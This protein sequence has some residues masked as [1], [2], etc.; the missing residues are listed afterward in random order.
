MLQHF[1]VE[2]ISTMFPKKVRTLTKDETMNKIKPFAAF[3]LA[4]FFILIMLDSSSAG[5]IRHRHHSR[6]QSCL[7]GPG[8][9]YIKRAPHC[10]IYFMCTMGHEGF[11]DACGCGCKPVACGGSAGQCPSDALVCTDSKGNKCLN[12]SCVGVSL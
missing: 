1:L 10:V 9:S 11:S 4:G 5:L 7:K 6:R 2:H 3:L 8:V 12:S